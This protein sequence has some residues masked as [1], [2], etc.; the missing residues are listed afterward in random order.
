MLKR[1]TDT[2]CIK[3]TNTDKRIKTILAIKITQ[4]ERERKIAASDLPVLC[5]GK[6]Q[7]WCMC[8]KWDTDALV[9]V[10]WELT[11]AQELL[12]LRQGGHSACLIKKVEAEPERYYISIHL[13]HK[14]I[15]FFL[16]VS[17][18][19]VM[20]PKS[21]CLANKTRLETI[22]QM[23]FSCGSHLLSFWHWR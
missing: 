6:A 18:H 2:A 11:T 5:W 21:H 9:R 20:Y 13:K 3:P 22:Q 23:L 14:F 7:C 12:Q 1:K 10:P 19:G 17:V 15:F 16:L 8:S 4:S